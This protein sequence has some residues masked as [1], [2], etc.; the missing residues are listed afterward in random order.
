L[1]NIVL[2]VIAMM[3]IVTSAAFAANPADLTA[4]YRT[5]P[6]VYSKAAY[7][8]GPWYALQILPV[9]KKASLTLNR[10]ADD[11]NGLVQ[12]EAILSCSAAPKLDVALSVEKWQGGADATDVVFDL[13][14]GKLGLGVHIPLLG[15]DVVKL[16]PRVSFGNFTAYS[17][18]PLDGGPR[19][20]GLTHTKHDLEV[21]VAFGNQTTFVRASYWKR[22]LV[23]EL[24]L[25]FTHEETFVGFA[26]V[27]YPH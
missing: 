11:T 10:W 25:K 3:V 4:D 8:G 2:I 20:Y 5:Y 18:F 12:N 27:Y 13:H 15:D 23:P 19:L 1:K 21:D 24:R 6:F 17:T 7:D 14:Q 22:N 16:G 26:L 9:G